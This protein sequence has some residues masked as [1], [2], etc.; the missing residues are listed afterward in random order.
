MAKAIFL[1]QN[2]SFNVHLCCF[3][4]CFFMPECGSTNVRKPLF[5]GCTPAFWKGK[6]GHKSPSVCVS[7]CPC[8]A[9]LLCALWDA[10]R[11]DSQ[12]GWKSLFM[13][14]STCHCALSVPGP[15]AATGWN[16]NRTMRRPR[17]LV[18][19]YLVNNCTKYSARL[20]A[21]A[22]MGD[23]EIKVFCTLITLHAWI[24]LDF[25]FKFEKAPEWHCTKFTFFNVALEHFTQCLKRQIIY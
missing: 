13:I 1:R 18:D 24:R 2:R 3:C 7:M 14:P 17:S 10:A 9:C 5:F 16:G 15:S 8:F 20:C 23:T 25:Q 22:W 11:P 12:N 6:K 21:C 4:I 19:G